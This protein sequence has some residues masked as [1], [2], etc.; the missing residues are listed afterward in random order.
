MKLSGLEMVCKVCE[1]MVQ[2]LNAAFFDPVVNSIVFNN[3]FDHRAFLRIFKSCEIVGWASGNSLTISLQY[4]YQP[5]VN[6]L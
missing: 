4:Q 5:S 3:A 2:F 6:I 1:L